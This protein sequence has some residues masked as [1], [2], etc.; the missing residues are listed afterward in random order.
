MSIKETAFDKI[1]GYIARRKI[2][3]TLGITRVVPGMSNAQ[4][5]THPSCS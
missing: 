5:S 4:F 2:L 1:E 3:S